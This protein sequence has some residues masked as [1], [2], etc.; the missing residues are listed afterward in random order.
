[1]GTDTYDMYRRLG[2]TLEEIW[3]YASEMFTYDD[4]VE[5]EEEE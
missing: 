5:I 2:W 3:Q 4:E 1:M